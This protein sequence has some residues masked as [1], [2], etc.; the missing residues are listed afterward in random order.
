MFFGLKSVSKF[1]FAE[2]VGEQIRYAFSD[3]SLFLSMLNDINSQE[4]AILSENQ[5]LC[6]Q[7][8]Q[9]KAEKK[10]ILQKISDQFKQ[11]TVALPFYTRL[12]LQEMNGLTPTR[13]KF[14]SLSLREINKGKALKR[15]GS[16]CRF[17]LSLSLSLSL[18]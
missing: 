7:L 16:N 3:L 6:A 12:P 5:D 14:T 10:E 13:K 8:E 9:E 2:D 11:I 15:S 17:S 4:E 18:S 1:H